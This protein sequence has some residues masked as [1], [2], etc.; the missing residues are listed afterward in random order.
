[1]SSSSPPPSTLETLTAELEQERRDRLAAE[2][3]VQ[4][5][6]R[7][8]VSTQRTVGRLTDSITRLT[9]N[10][11]VAVLVAH[12]NGMVALL[13]QEFCDLFGVEEMPPLGVLD[14][15]VQ[16]VLEALI[17]HSMRPE[18][19]RQRL[20]TMRQADQRVLGEDLELAD[21]TVLELDFIPLSGP[22][23]LVAAGY[24][25]SLRDVTQARRAEQYLH[26]LSRI[27]G[28]NPNLVLR[29]HADGRLLYS[30]PS[31]DVLRQEYL[32]PQQQP[33]LSE[34]LYQAAR[35]SLEAGQLVHREVR[36]GN[37]HLQLAIVPFVDDQYVNLYFTDITS[38]KEAE[39]RL[40]E[41]QE[42]Y[43]TVLNQLP[44]DVAVFDA[45][46][47]YRFV[48]P[49]AI[50]SKELRQWVIGH[51]DFE[52][53]AHRGRSDKQARDRRAR[54]EQAIRQ[55]SVLAWEERLN[56]PDGPRAGFAPHAGSF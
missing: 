41:Q 5:L 30:N 11:R 44:A 48:N 2:L 33:G 29:L 3:Q 47:R 45:E 18:A 40:V 42:F 55:R 50:R 35:E 22:D 9:Q 52:Y 37:Q 49:A 53:A 56:G 17:A 24:M 36:F 15:P 21:N 27:P 23:E 43:E 1:M 32:Y 54:F 6:R 16:P 28:Q 34:Q 38:L 51:D 10:L 46:H 39:Q 8:L 12:Q 19:T 4:T 14:Q 31:A 7:H 13:N 26:S 20:T 25:M